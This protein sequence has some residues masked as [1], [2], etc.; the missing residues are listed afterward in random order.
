MKKITLFVALL[1]C[2]IQFTL[3]QDNYKRVSISNVS[4]STIHQLNDLGID[5]T[6]G[7]IKTKDKITL[8]LFDIQLDQLKDQGINYNIL[9]DD[10]EE[11]YSQ[12]AIKD[13]PKASLELAQQKAQSATKSYSV[14][15]ILNNVG[16]YDA[17][18]EIDWA[19]P[20]NWKLNDATN[21]PAETNHFGGCLTYQ[22]V[23]DEL[24]LMR[25][26][27]PNLIS[28]KSDASVTPTDPAVDTTFEGRTVYYVRISD[29]PDTDEA[30]EPETLYQSL[31]H[32][33]EASTVMNQLFFMWYLLEN[34]NTD[35]AIKNLVN[36]QALYFI[37]VFNPDGF[38][39]NQ[40]Q[41][42]NGG[43]GQRKNRNTTVGGCST[44]LFGID[45]NRNSAYYWGNGGS[46]TNGCNDTYMGT[47]QFSENETQ[48]MRDFFLDHD[49]EL[50]LNHHSYKNAMLHAY[51]G[52]TITNPRPDEYSKY[53]HDMTYYNRYAHGP[54]TSISSLN[55]GNMNDW[56]LGGPAGTSA[57]G[58]PTGTGSGKETMAWTP[59]NGI[60]SEGSGGGYGGF[61]PQPS[62]YLPIAKR[63]MRMNFMAAYFSGKYAKLHDLNQS[64]ITS[65]SGNLSFAIENLGQKASDFTVTVT[66]VSANVL[67]VGP[68]VTEVFSAAQVLEQRTVNIAYTLDPSIQADDDI[69]FKVVLTNN[70]ASDNVL[71][72]ANILKKYTPTILFEDDPDTDSLT[73][74]TQT[75]TWYTTVDAFSGTTAITSTNIAPYSNSSSKQLQMNG[76]V[77]LSGIPTVLIQFYAKWDLERSFDYVQIEG[78]TNGSTWTPLCGKLTKP[79]APDSNNTYSGK[80]ATNNQFQPDGQ[81]LYDGD[82]QGKWNMEEIVIDATTNSFL[83]NQ[84]T[85]YLR[86]DFR[87]DGT[88]RQ[89]SYYN[90]NFEGFSFDDF[91]VLEIKV[92]CVTSIPTNLAVSSITATT[93]TADW[94][95]VPSATYDLRYRI[96]GAPTWTDVLDIPT[97]TYN[98]TGLSP[99]TD[100]EVQVRTKCTVSTSGYTSSVNFSTGAPCSGTLI[101]T[102]PYAESF[103]TGL[104][105]WTQDGSDNFDWTRNSGGTPTNNTG[106]SSASDGTWYLFTEASGRSGQT[107]IIN[108]PCFDLTNKS[109]ASFSFDRH[110]YGNQIGTLT[111][112]VSTDDGSNW[113]NLVS[114][115]SGSNNS[116]ISSGAI[117]LALYLN[118]FIKL[119]FVGV[120]SGNGSDMAID[121][122][123]LIAISSAQTWYADTD[124]DTFGD[125]NDSQV[126]VT[127]PA[128]YVLDNT[129]C[130]DS[131][132]SI[133]PGA[134]EI[135]CDG[136][137]QNC[138]GLADDTVDADGDG[139]DSC[140][141]C[142]D[143]DPSIYPG[144]TEVCDGIDNN[145]DGSI[146]EGFDIDADGYTT[147][148][149]DC[150]D[151]DPTINPGATEVCDGIDNNCDGSIDEGFD[152]D[153]DGY[154][155]CQGD[156]D[157]TDPTIYPG[158]TEI[159]CDGI[160]QNCNGLADDKVDADGDGVDSCTDCDDSDPTIY[161]GATEI[162]CNGIDENCNGMVD[163]ADS[164]DPI[165]VGQDKT[166]VLDGTGNASISW[167]D[168][169]NG[170]T[171]N[172][173]IDTMT[174]N[175]SSFNS[176]DVGPN[177]V[178]LTVTDYE[179]NVST[180]DVTVTVE[181]ETLDVT[182][183]SDA[184]VLITPNPFGSF[185]TIQLPMRFNNSDFE[186]EIF[187]LRG[188]VVYKKEMTSS[189]MRLNIN[190]LERLEE[191]PYI[192]KITS[193]IN[194]SS[195]YKK[196]IKHE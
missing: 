83:Y 19:V 154:T 103:E 193:K 17:C 112:Q 3:A 114:P 133:Y 41:A 178:T 130:N 137:D 26:L 53:N 145:C 84:S 69:E 102:F 183:F 194:G 124:G 42:P 27:Y 51:A 72:E 135:L 92:P 196:L 118:E 115:Y 99:L 21:Y 120:M 40:T 163:D 185:I 128:G 87:T 13:L 104:G 32:S 131:D 90:A 175:P 160:D 136:I 171:D 127:Q 117:D 177:T 179:G 100:Y 80:S 52:T 66:P 18:D 59:E 60:F 46:S 129:D 7:V 150:D 85:V 155:T 38:V 10:M 149:G 125:P 190:G 74:W 82:T 34:Y 56:M 111:L 158:A 77:D 93:A 11:Y 70:Y 79:G 172:C 186:V 162:E 81:P 71:Y 189:E 141:D 88:N 62:N 180:C 113:T 24:D 116:W 157:D 31:I 5:L 96:L 64:D 109:S 107:A 23:L 167:A 164:I 195:I 98:L 188:R 187:D 101:S 48:I 119:R 121:N 14:N 55:S 20:A 6:C 105:D 106:P 68:A 89:D 151:T 110:L 156:C 58:T 95:L 159:L 29:N 140:T 37:P 47:S 134:T 76:T 39:Y 123:G 91:K 45:L 22:M 49:F 191:A 148:Q 4:E 61:W 97:N 142:D 25:S 153:A 16:Q 138:N 28:V 169:D 161:P 94:D 75:G 15:E 126:S 146:D 57:N 12:R 139:V 43:G 173:G 65:T 86:F 44:Y 54:S 176:G 2:A 143:S 152:F 144:A 67:T 174:V 33:R 1:C 165:C 63:A 73:N 36:N 192:I 9:I 182:E 147:C 184:T 181:E 132:P 78:S 122:L 168:I 50:A 35:D 170:S 108:S 8:E 166:V 30:G